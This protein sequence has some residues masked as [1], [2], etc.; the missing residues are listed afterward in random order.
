[1]ELRGLVL[2]ESA[3][4]ALRTGHGQYLGFVILAWPQVEQ[5]YSSRIVD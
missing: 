5:D 3:G 4:Q 2:L 1:M